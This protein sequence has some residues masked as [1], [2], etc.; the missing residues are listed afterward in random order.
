MYRIHLSQ[1]Y[2][3]KCTFH[4][5]LSIFSWVFSLFFH[6]ITFEM[7]KYSITS[8]IFVSRTLR[9]F[10]N[11]VILQMY[12]KSKRMH[13]YD[14]LN[15]EALSLNIK[16]YFLFRMHVSAPI[17]DLYSKRNHQSEQELVV[18]KISFNRKPFWRS[19]SEDKFLSRVWN[20]MFD[21]N[22][23]GNI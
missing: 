13:Y 6:E 19:C 3:F 17:C 9:F 21:R 15:L 8:Y 5:A 4:L 12:R 16:I 18:L 22:R 2:V 20:I 11:Y 7:L 1:I 14:R 23:T 10:C